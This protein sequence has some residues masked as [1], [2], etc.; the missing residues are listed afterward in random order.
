MVR[1][2]ACLIALAY[3]GSA[4]L[5][6]PAATWLPAG[7]GLRFETNKGQAGP[8]ARF[9]GRGAGLTVFLTDNE[10]VVAAAKGEPVRLRPVGAAR[11]ARWEPEED[12]GFPT[13]Y[14]TGR[15]PE[16]WREGVSS[17]RRIRRAGLYPGIDLVFEGGHNRLEYDFVVAAG[18][19]PGQIRLQVEGGGELRIDPDGNLVIPTEAGNVVQKRP[20]VFQESGGERKSVFARWVKRNA[21]EVGF[22]TAPY[23][24]RLPL[25]IDPVIEFASFL[26]SN[27]TDQVT[28]VGRSPVS[29]ETI[30]AGWTDSYSIAGAMRSG[31]APVEG[32]DGFLMT[33]TQAG[34]IGLVAYLGGSGDDRI[35]GMA[36]SGLRIV[37][38]GETNSREFPVGSSNSFGPQPEGRYGGGASDA[39]VAVFDT[40][41]RQ[42]RLL[43]S[44][45]YGGSGEDRGNGVAI[46]GSAYYVTGETSSED[47]PFT[48]PLARSHGRKDAFLVSMTDYGFVRSQYLGGSGDDRGRAVVVT[49]N[50]VYVAGDTRSTDLPVQGAFQGASGGG[51]DG[52]VARLTTSVAFLT[53]LGGS[54]DDQVTGL[55]FDSRARLVVCGS[56]SSPDFPLVRPVQAT[57]GG[58]SDA[59]LAVFATGDNTL[60]YSTYF[61]GSGDEEGLSVAWNFEE[62][63]LAGRTSSENL[64][65]KE[66]LQPRPGGGEDGFLLHLNSRFEIVQATYFGGRG[67][68]AVT[69]VVFDSFGNPIVAGRSSSTDLAFPEAFRREAGGGVDGFVARIAL[70]RLSARD[71]AIG[72]DLQATA[73]TSLGVA[74]GAQGAEVTVTSSDAS[75][76]LVSTMADAAGGVSA[77]IGLSDSERTA[78]YYLQALTDDGEVSYT[79][80]A[81]GYESNTAKVTLAKAGLRVFIREEYTLRELPE[82]YSIFRSIDPLQLRVGLA[83]VVGD[84]GSANTLNVRGGLAPLPIEIR[85]SDTDVVRVPRA[86][87]LLTADDSLG[88]P[89]SVETRATGSAELA[90]DAP[91]LGVSKRSILDVRLPLLRMNDLRVGKDLMM[92]LPLFLEGR[93]PEETEITITSSDPSRVRLA[94]E[95]NAP[96]AASVKVRLR[97]GDIRASFVVEA[98]AGEGSVQIEATAPGCTAA[99]S[100]VTLTPSSFALRVSP[101][102]TTTQ[103]A[104]T[105]VYVY[106]AQLDPETREVQSFQSL[107]GGRGRLTLE[108]ASSNPEVGTLAQ[109]IL[110]LDAGRGYAYANT[111]FRPKNAGTTDVT[112]TI[113]AGFPEPAPP[114]RVQIKVDQ[115]SLQ[116]LGTVVGRNLRS[117]LAVTLSAPARDP[118]TVVVRNSDPSRVLVGE[119][120][121][122]AQFTVPRGSSGLVVPISGLADSGQVEMTASAAEYGSAIAWVKLFPTGFVFSTNEVRGRAFTQTVVEV[123]PVVLDGATGRPVVAQT[124]RPGVEPVR[125]AITSSKPEVALVRPPE[126]EIPPGAVGRAQLNLVSAGEAILR[127]ATPPGFVTPAGRTEIPVLAESPRLLIYPPEAIGMNLQRAIGIGVE[128]MPPNRPALTITSS[129]PQ[130]LLV[131]SDPRREGSASV[132]VPATAVGYPQVWAQALADEGAVTLTAKADQLREAVTQLRLT[133]SAFAIGQ[134]ELETTVL[135]QPSQIAV[136]VG[137]RGL[138][139]EQTLRAGISPVTVELTNSDRSIGTLS[140]SHL[141]FESGDRGK[142]SQFR[143]LAP[144]TSRITARVPD[145]FS[146]PLYGGDM[147]VTVRWP[148]LAAGN[149]VIGKDLQMAA[150]A[151]ADAPFPAGLSARITS[152]DPTKLLVSRSPDGQGM[153]SVI[154]PVAGLSGHFWLQALVSE[155]TASYRV[156]AE[157]FEPATATVKFVPSG[158]VFSG[159]QQN[160][161]RLTTSSPPTALALGIVPLAGSQW[162]VGSQELRGGF[163]LSVQV[164]SSRPEVVAVT[165]SPVML[166][167]SEQANAMVRATAPGSATVSI[168]PPAGYVAPAAGTSI[169]FVVSAAQLRLM[170]ATI[171]VGRSLQAPIQVLGDIRTNESLEITVRS[172]DAARLAVSPNERAA[173]SGSATFRGVSSTF[174]V[175]ALAAEGMA[176]ITVSAPGFEPARL[177]V[178]LRPSGFA[179]QNP[180]GSITI[181]SV[182]P[183]RRMT[184]AP[185]WLQTGTLEFG[186]FQQLAPMPAALQLTLANSDPRVGTLSQNTIGYTPLASNET[187]FRPLA[188]G[189]TIVAIQPPAGFS[190]PARRHEVAITVEQAALR[191]NSLDLGNNLRRELPILLPDRAPAD[192]QIT[193]RSSDPSRLLLAAD[194]IAPGAP[195]V[196]FDL[197]PSQSALWVDVRGLADSGAA[198]V[199]ATAPGFAEGRGTVTLAPSGFVFHGFPETAVA[200]FR[201]GQSGE[202]YVV[203]AQLDRALRPKQG[204]VLW[205]PVV[206]RTSSSTSGVVTLTPIEVLLPDNGAGAPIRI[207]AEAPG[208]TVISLLP[209]TGFSTPAVSSQLRIR[210]AE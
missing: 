171:D 189:R 101:V 77:R 107:R 109:S 196:V 179:F 76:L 150:Q 143:P 57:Q 14:F 45:Y 81:P 51:L 192:L 193:L 47:L 204:G 153:A 113:P 118:V 106:P 89:V 183:P 135:S 191:V 78:R 210:V 5:G 176:T 54:G 102:H 144:G 127:L 53:Y 186:E 60:E 188:L 163:E 83:A 172:S 73:F 1:R 20:F 154:A 149:F 99:S 10:I 161:T 122:P 15:D 43:A 18:A 42:L 59:F 139:S 4:V 148:K 207:R 117:T 114:N 138:S 70:P 142:T 58:A 12:L 19:D 140:S 123:T 104:E 130:R 152:L 185:A 160:P 94:A 17:Y 35:H 156:E 72:K 181:T 115:A 146:Q 110:T 44:D 105:S 22:E 206:V 79:V 209:P 23:D 182:S 108:L 34:Q 96:P 180:T 125:V 195:S 88:V 128:Q 50:G 157:G 26:G 66:A 200:D 177:T 74:P 92:P 141:V 36:V 82:R 21:G 159:N 7:P 62:L 124:L 201:V 162:Y 178:N 13:Y 41:Q 136:L 121:E 52:F 133:H 9:I 90:V 175:Q 167:R 131:S 126:I 158:V 166:R 48:A 93:L 145:G 111:V 40:S 194:S 112:L 61:G 155:G 56:T 27:G 80:S 68:D 55:G 98:L 165:N 46:S 11:A 95:P 63:A 119:G 38:T 199:I 103:S 170:P 25:T 173:G 174:W 164:V 100:I 28:S 197:L 8:A 65:V 32:V 33:L 86:A 71:Y 208:E 120:S 202:V 134:S 203:V 205:Q 169:D 137:P 24:L 31:S 3:S 187:E 87:F 67:D 49:G 132:T 37:V 75:K 147:N 39:F 6:Q 184:V 198:Q 30:I 129:D 84:S 16:R 97:A 151:S 190:T 2:F 29:G 168:L 69:A 116:M 85:S 91:R 64:P